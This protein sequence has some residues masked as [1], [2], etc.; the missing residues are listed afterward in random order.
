[1]SLKV[2]V[3]GAGPMGLAAA[4][5]L[6]KQG[7]SVEVF[8]A[9]P[10]PGGMAAHFDFDGLSIERFYHFVC[11]SD[12]PLFELLDELGL[13]KSMVWR[14][15][16]MGFFHRGK[17]HEWGNPFA[18]LRFPHL[19][20]LEKIRYGLN[21]F[22]S[23]KRSDWR[24]LDK[25]S[26]K[27]W[28]TKWIGERAYS[29][30][31]GPLLKLKFFELEDDISAAWVWS[32]IKRVGTSR[33]S[34]FQEQ[35]GY[36]RGGSE[37]LISSLVKEIEG[38]GGVVS[39]SSPAQRVVI[40]SGQVTGLQVKDRE[41]GF[42]RVIST[43]AMPYACKLLG[44]VPRNYLEMYRALPN[45]GVVCVIHKLRRQVSEH[46]WVN[47]SDSDIDIP[48]IIEFSNLRDVSPDHVV[49]VPYYM[50]NSHPKHQWSDNDFIRESTAYIKAI[51]PHLK[52]D[53][54]ISCQIS[55]LRF[56]QPVCAPG[57]LDKLPPISPGVKGLQVADTSFY[58]PEDRGVAES[59]RLARIM[60]GNVE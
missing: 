35:L 44:D 47:I 15:T 40:E 10:V 28:L 13:A 49:Y 50:P 58:Y 31:W 30:C 16:S 6:A 60:A 4:Y 18:L 11:K 19:T 52:D 21:A 59:V 7:H 3:I 12:A 53:D 55:R 37:T 56:S 23:T 36:L 41:I 46:F 24:E 42:D 17:L 45:I 9:A 43:I 57:F 26:A 34:I 29:I 14:D 33:K 27:S 48:G 22:T 8:E 38:M 20:F 51:G 25:Q 5:F 54:F 32:R 2:A 39:L 1:M